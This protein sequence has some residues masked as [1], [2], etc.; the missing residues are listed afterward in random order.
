MII[1]KVILI[2]ILN[3]IIIKISL[4]ILIMIIN[5]NK[6]QYKIM[7]NNNCLIMI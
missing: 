4:R 7:I 5:F 6:I 2:I 3:K 1:K